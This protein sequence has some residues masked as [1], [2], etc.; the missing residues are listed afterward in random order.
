MEESDS[1]KENPAPQNKRRKKITRLVTSS[2]IPEIMDIKELSSYLGI[3]KSKI[4]D[5]IRRKKIPASRIGRQYR[6]YRALIDRWLQEKLITG[7]PSELPL[8]EQ[9][10]TTNG[11]GLN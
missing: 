5:M 2:G 10:K 1:K 3:G 11:N 8:F 4:Y 9:E 7:A 6:F